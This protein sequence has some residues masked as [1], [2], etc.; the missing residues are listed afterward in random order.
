MYDMGISWDSYT[1]EC[2]R[3]SATS[4]LMLTK[5]SQASQKEVGGAAMLG[6]MLPEEY[7]DSRT[8]SVT[9]LW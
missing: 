6:A 7:S 4:F 9:I 2:R 5:G 8:L 3:C 1:E